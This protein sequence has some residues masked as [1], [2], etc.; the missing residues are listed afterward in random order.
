MAH[1][2]LRERMADPH[3]SPVDET[4]RQ[5]HG[6][7]VVAA[8]F[9]LAVLSWG[10]GFYGHAF[11]LAELQRLHGWPASLIA[12]AT[13]TYYLLGALLVIFVNDA[14]ARFGISACVLLGA[15]ALA[16]TTAALPFIMLPWQLFA[17]YGVMALAW[18]TMSLGA[19]NNIIGLWF[20]E[21]RGLAISLALNGA[22]FSGIVVVPALVFL[23]GFAGFTVAM[24]TGAAIVLLLAVPLALTTLRMPLPQLAGASRAGFTGQPA[25]P[26]AWTRGAALRSLAFWSVS[27]PF[28]LAITA[29]AGFLVHQIAFLEPAVGR[30]AAGIAVAVTTGMAITGRLTLG[31]I[32]HRLNLRMA[33]ALSF[34]AQAAAL[35]AMTQSAS[36]P[37]LLTACAVY[38]FS[39]G[40]LITFPALIVQRE[41]E[42]AAFGMLIGLSTGI[43]QF[44]YAFG[45]G[46]LGFVRD[47]TGSYTISLVVCILLN[48]TAAAIIIRRP[49]SG[50]TS[51]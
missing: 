14:M 7:R 40:N 1:G 48:L 11:Y 33:I 42:P 46:L 20:H 27:V 32:A 23:T 24:L 28:A 25:A 50:G 34:I 6:W 44:T 26:T 12:S 4:S 10:F 36:P 19:I 43:S 39:V 47:A 45:P 9:A 17:V 38:G 5:Y 16:A 2:V 30:Y 18:A 51:A 22:S 15:V 31:T 41:F 35:G 37:V 13:T 49:R 29:Q 21:R 3:T 8:C